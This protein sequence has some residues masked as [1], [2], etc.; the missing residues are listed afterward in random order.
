MSSYYLSPWVWLR[1][2]RHR[3]GYGVHSPYAFDFIAGVIYERSAY[4]AYSRLDQLLPRWTR[5]LGLRPRKLMRLLFRLANFAHPRRGLLLTADEVARAYMQAAVPSA[6]WSL[7]M[8]DAPAAFDFVYLDCPPSVSP[9]TPADGSSPSLLLD[10]VHPDSVLVLGRLRSNL[11]LWQGL[12]ADPR[13]A[14]SFDLYDVGILMF[15][16]RLNR[17]DY[18]VNF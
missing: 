3:C 6:R 10:R 16:K 2:F 13:V 9:A 1:R 4:Y 15:N 14:I 5:R 18:I 12:L 17:Q 8:A 7:D 11:P